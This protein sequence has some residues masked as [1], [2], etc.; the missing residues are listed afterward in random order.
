[1]ETDVKLLL[2]QI[3][4]LQD[5][6]DRRVTQLYDAKRGHNH[7]TVI[8]FS[9]EDDKVCGIF[10]S[11][12]D[13]YDIDWVSLSVE[14]IEMS[15]EEWSEYITKVNEERE[16]K[17]KQKEEERLRLKLEKDQREYERLKRQFE[18]KEGM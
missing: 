13:S 7:M 8:G 12:Y 11:S 6:I 15:N 16:L 1:M 4:E 10:N 5:V 18:N 14:Q 2:K 17:E 3:S 9:F